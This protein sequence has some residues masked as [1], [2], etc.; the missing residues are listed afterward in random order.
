M[1]DP[2]HLILTIVH[3]NDGCFVVTAVVELPVCFLQPVNVP[4]AGNHECLLL[5]VPILVPVHGVGF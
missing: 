5:I 1:L 3:L 4:C 2:V